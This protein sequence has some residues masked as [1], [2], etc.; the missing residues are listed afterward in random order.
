MK[1]VLILASALI[2]T[3][4]VCLANTDAKTVPTKAPTAK[5]GEQFKKMPPKGPDFEKRRQEFEKRLNLTDKQKEKAEALHKAGFE[6][7]KPIMEKTKEKQK[8]LKALK[9]AK[10]EQSVQKAEQIKKEIKALREEARELQKQNMKDFENILTKKQKKELDKM[11]EEGRKNFEKNIKN[12]PHPE[13]GPHP[14]EPP[15]RETK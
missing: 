9:D 7:M 11:K 4:T 14:V 5:C 8:A 2:F 13:H 3:T 10:D 12:R 6:K 1:K 15:V